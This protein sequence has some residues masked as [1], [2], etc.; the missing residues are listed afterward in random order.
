MTYYVGVKLV[1]MFGCGVIKLP[2]SS[3][4]NSV[5]SVPTP[6]CLSLGA[7]LDTLESITNR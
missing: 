4:L 1:M 3:R 6:C 2:Y 5:V 7:G